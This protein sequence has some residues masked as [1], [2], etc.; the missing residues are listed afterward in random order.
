MTGVETDADA[1]FVLDEGDDG[2]EVVECGA[3]DVSG[4]GHGF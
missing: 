4:A 2:G 3:D 1:A